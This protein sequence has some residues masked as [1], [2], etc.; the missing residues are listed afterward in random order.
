MWSRV[1]TAHLLVTAAAAGLWSSHSASAC[2]S[3][4]VPIE[5]PRQA[6]PVLGRSETVESGPTPT[7]DGRPEG[8]TTPSARR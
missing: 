5:S 4:T 6:T 8:A 7:T 1:R 3:I 2:V